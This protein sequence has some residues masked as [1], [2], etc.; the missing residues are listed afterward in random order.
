MDK[1]EEKTFHF[2][3]SC[4]LISV[5]NFKNTLASRDT[6]TA[7][8]N[9]PFGTHRRVVNGQFFDITPLIDSKGAIECDNSNAGTLY[10]NRSQHRFSDA[11]NLTKLR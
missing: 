9:G 5:K 11:D 7:V 4:R 2:D 6:Q 10:L 1:L 3:I 8:I